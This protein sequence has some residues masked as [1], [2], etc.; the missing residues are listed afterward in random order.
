MPYWI[1]P[2]V[3]NSRRRNNDNAKADDIWIFGICA[4]ELFHG[5]PPLTPLPKSQTLLQQ[6]TERIGLLDGDENYITNPKKMSDKL[7][8]MVASCLN[9]NPK[10][11]PPAE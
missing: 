9:P 6:I 1:A 11:R 10:C 4:L 8:G 3:R 7:H 2:G 5:G